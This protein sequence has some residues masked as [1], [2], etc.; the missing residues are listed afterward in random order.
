MQMFLKLNNIPPGRSQKFGSIHYNN[1]LV[2]LISRD[3]PFNNK[4]SRICLFYHEFR[5]EW[6]NKTFDILNKY[7]FVLSAFKLIVSYWSAID[8]L[9]FYWLAFTFPILNS[10]GIKSPESHVLSMSWAARQSHLHLYD[11]A[12][13]MRLS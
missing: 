10:N 5:S 12:F 11:A 7:L 9:V 1:L 8:F 4:T 6:L 2:S 13:M 3:C